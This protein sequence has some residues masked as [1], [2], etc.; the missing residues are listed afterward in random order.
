MD[1]I[2]V[3]DKMPAPGMFAD[4]PWFE[5]Y[6]GDKL[7]TRLNAAHVTEVTYA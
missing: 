3:S 6:E 4:L 7:V 5:V 2:K 1:W